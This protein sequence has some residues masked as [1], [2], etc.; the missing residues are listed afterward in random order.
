MA[1]TPHLVLRGTTYYFRMAVPC[2]LVTKV[3]RAEVS[4][5]LRTFHR[6][7]ATIRCRY[8]SNSLDV[9]F[10]RLCVQDG[11]S[12]EDIDAEIKAYFQRA[13][14]WS[15]EYVEVFMDDPVLDADVEAAGLPDLVAHYQAQLKSGQFS[16]AIQSEASDLLAPLLPIGGKADLGST[17]HACRGIASAKIE[18]YRRLIGD[19]TG[20]H[21]NLVQSDPRFVAMAAA[22]YPALADDAGKTDSETLQ[23]IASRFRAHKVEMG[24]APKTLS[25]FDVTMRFAYEIVPPDRPIRAVSDAD[26][27]GIRDLLKRIPPNALKA[28]AAAGQSF[29]QLAEANESGP[30][31]AY[32]T[33]EKRLRFFRAMLNWASEEGYLDKVPG[34]K[35]A[36]AGKKQKAKTGGPYSREDL[37]LIF[38]TP[39]YTGRASEARASTVG[40]YIFKD[41]KFWVPLIGLFS[42]MRLGEI[43]Q[44]HRSDLVCVDG[45]WVFDINR[46]EDED[47]KVKTETSLRQVPV[48]TTLIGLGLLERRTNDKLGKRLFPDLQPGQN[49]FYSHNFSKWWSRYGETFGFRGEKKVFHSFRHL[50]TDALRD[51]EAPDYVLKAVLGHSDK[52]IT[53]SYGHGA[54]LAVRQSY[55]DRVAFDAVALNDLIQRERISGE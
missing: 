34:R 30:H 43:V 26:V 20:D 31:L 35:V 8:L 2:Q 48:H 51:L 12:F 50:F 14:N 33:Q 38:S 24:D 6:K 42:G 5:S 27:R 1:I 47:K 53:A 23:S 37:E 46:A 4:A 3:G 44:L 10:Q 41:G 25:D 54:K 39:V 11:P 17:R 7:E 19:L 49:G 45:V 52:S 22:G 9:Y 36:V 13:L 21:S 28:K 29:T 40:D 32:A 15:L 16:P 55:I 18:Q